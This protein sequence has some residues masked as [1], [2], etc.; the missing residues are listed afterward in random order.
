MKLEGFDLDELYRE[1]GGGGGAQPGKI[2]KALAVLKDAG[3]EKGKDPETVAAIRALKKLVPG[4]IAAAAVAIA[5][6]VAAIAYTIWGAVSGSG[7]GGAPLVLGALAAGLAVLAVYYA[8]AK[9]T[10]GRPW[11]DFRDSIGL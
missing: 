5:L 8:I 10:F 11:Y 2:G 1:A 3:A 7:A 6:L 4:T 9:R